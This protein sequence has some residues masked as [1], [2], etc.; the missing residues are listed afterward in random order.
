MSCLRKIQEY[1]AW[2]R[3][4]GVWPGEDP[5]VCGLG[6]IQGC[7]AWGRNERGGVVLPHTPPPPLQEHPECNINAVDYRGYSALHV[8]VLER[9]ADLVESLLTLPGI[10][11]RDTPLHAVRVGSRTILSMLL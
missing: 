7:V 11:L 8:A 5:G 10:R 9:N 6:K 1:L 4:R 3:S 2:G